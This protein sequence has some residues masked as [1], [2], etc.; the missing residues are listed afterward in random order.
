MVMN[1][2]SLGRSGLQ[3]WLIQRATAMVLAAYVLFVLGVF[4]FNPDITYSAWFTLFSSTPVR[5]F[6]LFA[7]LSFV[8]HAWVGIWIVTT[9][10]IKCALLRVAVQCGVVFWLIG[11]LAWGLLILWSV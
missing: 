11:C 7:I 6:T 2:T 10:Y 5:L 1:A 8:M 9:D 3:D 4:L